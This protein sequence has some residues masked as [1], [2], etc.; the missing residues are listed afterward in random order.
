MRFLILTKSKHLF[1][2]EAMP[3][4]IAAMGGWVEKYTN[5][6]KLEQTWS[7]AGL[8]G[9]GGIFNVDSLEE[10]DDTMMEFPFGPFSEIEIYGLADLSAALNKMGEMVQQ[11][12]QPGS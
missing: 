6:K 3:G 10:L 5:E 12:A 2:P 9:G 11:M 4:L 8:Q 1:P 7:F